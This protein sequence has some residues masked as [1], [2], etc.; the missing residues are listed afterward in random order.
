V[1]YLGDVPWDED[2]T[3]RLWYARIKSRPSFRALLAD[4]VPGMAPA[5]HYDNL[6][7]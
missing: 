4:R 5:E 2:E 6:D 3:A 7:F 1:D